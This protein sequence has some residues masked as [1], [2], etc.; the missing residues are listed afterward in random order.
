MTCLTEISLKIMMMRN[1]QEVLLPLKKSIKKTRISLVRC[2]SKGI[3]IGRWKRLC[4]Q[5]SHLKK[6]ERG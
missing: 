4:L 5:A 1:Y 2:S 3:E 6:R